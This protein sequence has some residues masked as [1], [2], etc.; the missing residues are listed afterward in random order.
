MTNAPLDYFCFTE[1]RQ[2]AIALRMDESA[3][4]I[5]SLQFFLE[6]L[7]AEE[8]EAETILATLTRIFIRA[9]KTDPEQAAFWIESFAASFGEMAR[10]LR[11]MAKTREIERVLQRSLE[12]DD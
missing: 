2:S 10:E 12:D 4:H 9:A 6:K 8:A 1:V 7:G 11:G 5:D 3:Q